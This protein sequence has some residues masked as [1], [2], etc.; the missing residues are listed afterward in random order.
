MKL[1]FS[2][3]I[4]ILCLGACANTTMTLSSRNYED[5]RLACLKQIK[6]GK[7]IQKN[8]A[9]GQQDV[10]SF[11]GQKIASIGPQGHVYLF[12][13]GP[14]GGVT[15]IFE[16]IKDMQTKTGLNIMTLRC[17]SDVKDI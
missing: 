15:H 13:R 12:L 2:A 5:V 16:S 11:W 1:L 17:M 9:T 8:P 14:S 6:G 3:I 7:Y 10:M 4:G